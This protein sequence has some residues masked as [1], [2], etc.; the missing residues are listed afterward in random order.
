MI[1]L[2]SLKAKMLEIRARSAVSEGLKELSDIRN[3]NITAKR[4]IT[5]LDKAVIA[6]KL[7]KAAENVALADGLSKPQE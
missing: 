3:I 5:A 1:N 4:Y 2:E 7:S 6:E